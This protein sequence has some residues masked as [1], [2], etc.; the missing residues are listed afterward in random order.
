MISGSLRVD[1]VQ[2]L[3]LVMNNLSDFRQIAD[4]FPDLRLVHPDL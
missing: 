1:L 3:P 4:E 2:D